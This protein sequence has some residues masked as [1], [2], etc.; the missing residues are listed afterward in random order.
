[1]VPLHVKCK[2]RALK[3]HWSSPNLHVIVRNFT[4][5]NVIN[6][7][8]LFCCFTQS[9]KG[10]QDNIFIHIFSI[11]CA[12]YFYLY[13]QVSILCHLTSAWGHSFSISWNARLLAMNYHRFVLSKN[14]FIS[15]LFS[16]TYIK[17]W[18][19]RLCIPL[20]TLRILFPCFLVFL[21]KNYSYI[22]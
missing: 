16:K 22:I 19:D 6:S 9:R 10:K 3:F 1:M 21:M 20:R 18:V 7:T 13:S 4:S 11:S 12:L 5:T 14:I 17:F 2:H 8:I 15:T